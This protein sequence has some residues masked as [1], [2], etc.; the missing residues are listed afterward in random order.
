MTLQTTELPQPHC[1]SGSAFFSCVALITP[2]LSFHGSSLQ[3]FL[4]PSSSLALRC[5]SPPVCLPSPPVCQLVQPEGHQPL[6]T[7][8]V[9][10]LCCHDTQ[11][12]VH[13]SPTA[14][15]SFLRWQWQPGF[16]V[17]QHGRLDCPLP[18]NNLVECYNLVDYS[19]IEQW[20]VIFWL[21]G[22]SM[23]LKQ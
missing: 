21:L 4:M 3:L 23:P 17:S 16:S 18:G 7:K 1:R 19:G 6:P 5:W 14:P 10:P 13:T 22:Y 11:E 8:A 15:L 20:N 12:C 2:P 9:V